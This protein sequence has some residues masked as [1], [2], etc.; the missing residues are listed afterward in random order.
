MDMNS[1]S[2]LHWYALRTKPN[3]EVAALHEARAR[4][5]ETFYPYQRYRPVNPRALTIRPYFPSYLFVRVNLNAKGLSIFQY[6]PYAIGLV[7]FGGEP[8][9]VPDGLIHALQRR[10][11]EL[12]EMNES[13]EGPKK[14]DR[15]WIREGPFAGQAA[16]FDTRLSGGDRVRLLLEFLSGR[17][18]RLELDAAQVEYSQ[19][20]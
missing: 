14:S 9:S 17:S 10:M 19:R 6:M 13:R 8:A 7:C 2:S 11:Q 16:I 15:V 5:I 1:E 20:A 3:R 12:G 4:D 18:V